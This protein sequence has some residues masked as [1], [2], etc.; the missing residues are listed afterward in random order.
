MDGSQ[1]GPVGEMRIP[2]RSR[3]FEIKTLGLPDTSVSINRSWGQLMCVERDSGKPEK[4]GWGAGARPE[5]RSKSATDPSEDDRRPDP[6]HKP[7]RDVP[8]TQP[9]SWV[10]SVATSWNACH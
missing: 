8:I 9:P 5:I 6:Q 7:H 2:N 1:G 4:G 3:K 10:S